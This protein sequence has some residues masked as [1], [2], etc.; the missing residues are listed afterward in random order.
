M[1]DGEGARAPSRCFQGTFLW[2]ALAADGAGDGA[3]LVP[4][5]I[6]PELASQRGHICTGGW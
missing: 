1:V 3:W 2:L 4:P 6:G 5:T